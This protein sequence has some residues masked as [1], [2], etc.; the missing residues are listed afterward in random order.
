M[1][2]NDFEGEIIK[3]DYFTIQED[4]DWDA[5][6]FF[7]SR[8]NLFDRVRRSIPCM[9]YDAYTN[10]TLD[11]K[12]IIELKMR[13]QFHSKYYIECGKYHYLINKMDSDN[14]KGYYLN[15]I[16]GKEDVFVWDLSKCTNLEK[17]YN[18]KIWNEGKQEYRYE[19]RYLLPITSAI[20]YKY[21]KYTDSYYIVDDKEKE[22][23]AE[24][25][26]K[27]LM[28]KRYGTT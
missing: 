10:N 13:F 14:A 3:R 2:K 1:T 16:M 4:K 26:V 22:R 28:I 18:I 23:Y 12:T 25:V 21:N 24:E 6:V 5:L 19:D 11:G 9:R 27:E 20:H 17:I 15:F 8:V 7:N